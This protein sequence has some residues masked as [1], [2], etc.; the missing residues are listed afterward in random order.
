M[1]EEGPRYAIVEAPSSLGLR[2]LVAA[3]TAR[4]QA[5]RAPNPPERVE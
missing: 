5:E 1:L 3:L 4:S 2:S